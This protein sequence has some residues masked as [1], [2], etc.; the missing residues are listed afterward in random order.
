MTIFFLQYVSVNS[1]NIAV[2]TLQEN[3]AILLIDLVTKM[4]TD[5]FTAGTVDLKKIDID[6]EDVI[7]QS[8]TL[9]DVPREPDGVAWVDNE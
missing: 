8:S 5:S 7:D 9:Y 3:N 6:E 1:N 2:V 4:V